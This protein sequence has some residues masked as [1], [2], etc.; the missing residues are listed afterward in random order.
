MENIIKYINNYSGKIIY[1]TSSVY[2][3][4]LAV[5]ILLQTDKK[6]ESI[7]IMTSPHKGEVKQ[8]TSISTRLEYEK[9][10]NI[11][12][13]KKTRIHRAIGISSVSNNII[14]KKVYQILDTS[15]HNFLLVNFS[16]AQKKVAYPAS[17]Y[18]DECE[19]AIFIQEGVMQYVT[20]DDNNFYLFLKKL[21]GNQTNFWTM[22]K[23]EGIYVN[24]PEKFPNYL[25]PKLIKANFNYDEKQADVIANIFL[26]E[27]ERKEL[28][29]IKTADGIIFTQPLSEDGFI[30]EKE[31][32]NIYLKIKKICDQC[33]KF[34]IKLHPRD[35]SDYDIDK[36]L[37]IKGKYPSEIFKMYHIKF[38]YAVG[39]C[40][41]AI[42]TI[43]ADCAFNLNDNFLYDKKLNFEDIRIKMEDLQQKSNDSNL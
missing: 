18:L 33:G 2:N 16:W 15:K 9:I 36:N 28:L 30:S 34:V 1:V 3:T 37:L 27:D 39:I 21:Y 13:D 20:P 25:Y 6:S 23:I 14:K 22:D 24:I 7:I 40:T 11:V 38:K 8:F 42:T 19:K 26:S 43:D 17:I 4:M 29:E 5:S 32:K 41:S 35:T 31:K 10:N 12:I